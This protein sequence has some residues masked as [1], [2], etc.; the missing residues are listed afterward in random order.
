MDTASIPSLHLRASA[1]LDAAR[2]AS[3][4]IRRAVSVANVDGW[5]IAAFAAITLVFSLTSRQ[6]FFW[7]WE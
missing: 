2:L 3:K 1:Q 4:K 6:E 7:A 5:T